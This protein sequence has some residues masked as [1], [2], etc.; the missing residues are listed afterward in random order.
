MVVLDSVASLCGYDRNAHGKADL[1]PD[2]KI[3]VCNMHGILPTVI[4]KWLL[5]I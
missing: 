3:D 1:D 5:P 4:I 2:V